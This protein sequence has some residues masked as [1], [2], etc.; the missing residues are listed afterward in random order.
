MV[1]QF[2]LEEETTIKTRN[3]NVKV[4]A[5]NGKMVRVTNQFTLAQVFA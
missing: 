2:P 4:R 5:G 1:P 3:F